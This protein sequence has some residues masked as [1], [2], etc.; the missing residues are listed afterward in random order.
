M[1]KAG[2][3]EIVCPKTPS[4]IFLNSIIINFPFNNF[5]RRDFVNNFIIRFFYILYYSYPYF[6]D[7][8]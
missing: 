3:L 5:H 6:G 8:T 4:Y 1:L 2:G 7:Y